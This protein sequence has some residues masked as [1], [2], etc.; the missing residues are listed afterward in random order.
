MKVYK[1]DVYNFLDLVESKA[2]TS[3][4]KR[5]AEQIAE[6]K[7]QRYQ[8]IAESKGRLITQL[9]S[10]LDELH[11]VEESGAGNQLKN[12]GYFSYGIR[13]LA[14]AIRNFNNSNYKDIYDNEYERQLMSERD[15]L[16]QEVT[17]E[18]ASLKAYCKENKA[19]DSYNMLKDLGFDVSSIPTSDHQIVVKADKSKLFVCGDNK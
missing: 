17:K 8:V 16:I 6:S 12:Y 9:E 11:V 15:Q 5:F 7:K 10:I 14:D 13:D 3:V 4:K 19:K 18:Y 1:K 2:I